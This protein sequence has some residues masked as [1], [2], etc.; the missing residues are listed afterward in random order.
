MREILFVASEQITANGLRDI[1]IK[2][3]I[4]ELMMSFVIILLFRT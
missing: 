2:L 4:A 1:I 3:N